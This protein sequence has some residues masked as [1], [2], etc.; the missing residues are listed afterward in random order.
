MRRVRTRDFT[1]IRCVGKIQYLILPAS[2]MK[3]PVVI[4]RDARI[5]ISGTQPAEM[6]GALNAFAFSTFPLHL[7]EFRSVLSDQFSS[8]FLLPCLIH[9]VI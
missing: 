6:I 8:L 1:V 9:L 5:K 3:N 2:K 4:E 7:K